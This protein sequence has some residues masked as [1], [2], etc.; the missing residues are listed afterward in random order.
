MTAVVPF[1]ADAGTR[2]VPSEYGTMNAALAVSVAGDTVLVAPGVYT[3]YQVWQTSFGVIALMAFIPDGVVLRSEGGANVTEL[4]HGAASTSGALAFW[5]EG[6][7]TGQTVIEGFRVTTDSA[8]RG[9]LEHILG[10]KVTLR[11]CRFEGIDVGAF[12]FEADLALEDCAFSDLV[13]AGGG[14][15]VLSQEGQV[16]MTRCTF[17]NC[18][19][20]AVQLYGYPGGHADYAEIRD[21]HFEGNVNPSNEGG[22]LKVYGY[23]QG[24]VLDGCTFINNSTRS[25]SPPGQGGAAAIGGLGTNVVTNCVF[26]GNQGQGMGGALLLISGATS[27]GVVSGCTFYDNTVLNPLFGGGAALFLALRGTASNNIFATTKGD[28]ALSTDIGG[29]ITTSCNIFW[30]NEAGIGVTL[31]PT[32]RIADP[33][34]CDPTNG[35]LSVREGSPCLPPYSNGCG[36]IGALGDGC[37][38]VS[39]ESK[40]WGEIKAAYRRAEAAP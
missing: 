16:W 27:F 31:S 35:D 21:C 19:V 7:T 22:A 28:K 13:V 10:G 20:G 36:Q 12:L 26:R 25:V 40:S 33:L 29:T 3:D 8:E 18:P 9:G 30:D 1:V 23:G 34:F 14:G 6:H 15:A 32:D 24:V 39:V 2:R 11:S 5:T 38:V 37:G 17:M 4:R